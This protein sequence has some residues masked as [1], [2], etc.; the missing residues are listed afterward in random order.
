MRKFL[1]AAAVTLSAGAMTLSTTD[2]AAAAGA[3]NLSRIPAAETPAGPMAEP[4]AYFMY[5]KYHRGCYRP[6]WCT[7]K[8]GGHYKKCYWG[9]CY[10]HKRYY[11]MY[12]KHHYYKRPR[13]YYRH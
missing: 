11:H 5:R 4:V 1:F 3:P 6:Y 13:H 2:K 8:Y 9:R 12:K 7:Y 10:Y